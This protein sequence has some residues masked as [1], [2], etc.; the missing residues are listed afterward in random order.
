MYTLLQR[1]FL[2]VVPFLWK[3]RASR[4]ATAITVGIVL[5]NTL[6]Y[7]AAPWL[8]GYL[9]KHYHDLPLNTVLL[10]VGLLLCA[11]CASIVLDR[12]RE[13]IFFHIVNQAIRDIRLRVIMQLHQVPLKAWEHYGVT[14]IVSANTRVGMSIRHFM[15]IT[16]VTILPALLKIGAFSVTMLQVHRCTW[17][18]P[19]LVLL[20]YGYV[21]RAL[22]SFLQS[23]RHLWEATD[24]VRTAMSDSLRN[25]KFSRFHL[26]EE[27]ARLNQLFDTEAQGWLRNNAQLHTMHLVQ[28]VLF[29]VIAGGLVG[30]LVL[31]L[32]AGQLTVPDFVVIKG[33]IFA[34]HSQMYR[35]TDHLRGLFGSVI[36]LK[37][38]L[39]ILALPTHAAPETS[40]SVSSARLT[41]QP[42]V[43]Q[44]RQVS[45]SYA[46]HDPTLLQDVSLDIHPGDKLALMGPSGVGKSTLCHVL[47]GI[48]QPT[49]GE[50][51]LYGTPMQQLSL[52]TIGQYIHLVDQEAHIVQGTLADN[53]MISASSAQTAP[54]AYLKDRLDQT[55]G[56][57]GKKLSSGEK[58][59]MLLARSLSYQP[60]VLILDETL[61]ALDEDSA[62]ELLQLVLQAVPTVILVTHRVSLVQ[63]FERIYRLQAGRLII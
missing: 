62:Q 63:G 50:V 23:R 58:Q 61:S 25:T 29:F 51:R 47:A 19:P 5:L 44:A 39:D 18:F 28:S 57:G 20:T 31:L 3:D 1:T 2:L 34:I 6:A 10:V 14:E 22:R 40:L 60:E 4:V 48:Y 38:V 55:T 43:L 13:I 56:E 41:A 17:Y 21:Y 32:R 49:Q 59:R 46:G 45:F 35:I 11:W 8:L 37:K 9:L 16:F 27:E 12:P 24:Q 26:E 42:P 53:L 36:D 52:A 30:H 33:Y 7:A 54:L 15:R